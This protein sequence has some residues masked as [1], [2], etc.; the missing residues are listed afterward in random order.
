MTHSVGPFLFAMRHHAEGTARVEERDREYETGDGQTN[1]L[2][3]RKDHPIA[4]VGARDSM[5]SPNQ[6]HQ[7]ALAAGIPRRLR[8]PRKGIDAMVTYRTAQIEGLSVFYHSA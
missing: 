4:L 3:P 5:R 8:I 2:L 7:R 1:D 6:I